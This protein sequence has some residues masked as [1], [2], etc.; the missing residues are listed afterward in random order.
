MTVHFIGAGPG[1]PELLTIKGKR[2]LEKA[3]VVVYAGSLINPKVLKYAK[4]GAE[5]YDS[6][7]MTLEEI[8]E[9]LVNSSKSGKLVARLQ[10]GDPSIYGAI[11]EQIDALAKEEIDY[12]IIPGVSSIFAAAA[13][14]GKEYTVPG[15]SQSLIITRLSGWTKVPDGEDLAEMAKHGSSMAI[16]LSVQ[17]MDE[18]V[19]KLKEGYDGDTPA[20]VV[21]RASWDDEKIIT[22][23]LS[24]IAE[25]TRAQG[26]SK[27][28]LVLVGGFLKAKGGRSRLYAGDFEHGFRKNL[29]GEI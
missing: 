27:T 12:K 11:A 13:S 15:G 26:I 4:K 16:F 22:G 7:S 5:L 3:D 29:R 21:Y 14:L 6:S 8:I 19:K 23:T 18:V 17:M 9:V 20:A 24:G 25:K 2:I 28:A 1:D 10:S